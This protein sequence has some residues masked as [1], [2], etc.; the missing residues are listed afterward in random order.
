MNNRARLEHVTSST[1]EHMVNLLEVTLSA[2][3]EP[4]L[5]V[6]SKH[7][8]LSEP[9]SGSLLHPHAIRRSA[10]HFSPPLVIDLPGKRY[11]L[12]TWSQL[13]LGW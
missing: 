2:N 9:F 8:V 5:V 6:Y 1:A 7:S 11:A 4:R 10:R 13:H 12:V 3:S